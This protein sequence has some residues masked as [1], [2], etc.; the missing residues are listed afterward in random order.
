MQILYEDT[1]PQELQSL[2]KAIAG[3]YSHSLLLHDKAL[4]TPSFPETYS[5]TGG[6]ECKSL[7]S[8][9]ALYQEMQKRKFDSKSILIAC[10]GGSITDL[11]GFAAAT[12][13]R[14]IALAL[15]PTTLLGMVDAAIGG[16]NGLNFENKKNAIG[17]IYHP[18]WIII[19]TRWL[20]SL[21]PFQYKQG[22]AEIIKYGIINSDELLIYIENNIESI[23]NRNP[24]VLIPLIQRCIDI[25]L[26]IVDDSI[27]CPETRDL[28]NFGH[29]FGHAIEAASKF[30][31][32]HGEAVAMGMLLSLKL[33]AK[34]GWIDWQTVLRVSRILKAFEL[35]ADAPQMDPEE[36]IAWMVQDKKSSFGKICLILAQEIGKVSRF[37]DI[38]VEEVKEV[39]K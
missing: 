35:P 39:F 14:G 38:P 19:N 1:P 3:C 31:V 11:G 16:K 5:I 27:S 29:T 30:Q 8:A 20:D 22:I 6:E 37:P 12:Y 23:Q 21:D 9:E 26:K 7:T 36:L 17:T 34:R 32:P 25:K 13:Y 28:L 33:S 18:Q 4:S 10:G 24:Q 15:I 2:K